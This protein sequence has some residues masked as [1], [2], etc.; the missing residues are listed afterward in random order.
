MTNN[1]DEI[2]RKILQF[3]Y[4][5]YI[6]APSINRMRVTDAMVRIDLGKQGYDRN[7]I[8][9]NFQY[10]VQTGYIKKET[11]AYSYKSPGYNR[12][13][14]TTIK[15]KQSYYYISDIGINYFDGPSQFQKSSG[16]T[17]IN[18]TNVQGVTV[19]G[20]NNFVR[21]EYNELFKNLDTLSNELRR[22][23][24][25]SDE[26]KVSYLA[27]IETIKQQ[28]AKPNPAASIIKTAW[29]SLNA[30]STIEG[31]A[32]FYERVELLIKPLIQ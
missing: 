19:I 30:L 22:T 8:L 13:K 18:V 25:V 6:S 9:R 17:G 20:N 29:L 14:S 27:D 31:L 7:T 21:N 26:E 2:R 12:G 4:D 3:M 32:Q 11:E 10:L 5:K 24:K 16:I 23:D 1:N 15:G 28:L